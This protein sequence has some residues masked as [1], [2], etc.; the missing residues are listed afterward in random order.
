MNRITLAFAAALVVCV[1]TVAPSFAQTS[2]PAKGKMTPAAA[3]STKIM[4]KMDKMKTKADAK[5]DK[6][7]AKAEAKK[8]AMEAKAVAQMGKMDAKADSAKAKADM[9]AVKKY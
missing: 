4:E 2:Q 1:V 9:K 5:M 6:V 3:D 8:G 7:K